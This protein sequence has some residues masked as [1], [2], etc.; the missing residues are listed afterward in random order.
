MYRLSNKPNTVI[1]IFDNAHIQFNSL[2]PQ[3][4]QY[5]SW[6]EAGN[7]P[8]PAN[9]TPSAAPNPKMIGILF[10]GVMC[11]AT[12]E[13]QDG[14]LA[15]LTAYQIQGT[16]F[17]PTKF[18]FQNGNSL[19]ITKANIQQFISVWMPFRQSFFVPV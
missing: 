12:K 9:A 16:N 3:Y 6:L 10:Q 7:T 18:D 17:Q 14:L 19:V 2:N 5:L 11:S 13:D 15:V 8:A 4:L 1:R